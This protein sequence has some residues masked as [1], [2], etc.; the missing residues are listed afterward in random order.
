MGVARLGSNKLVFLKAVKPPSEGDFSSNAAGV[1]GT[2]GL[3]IAAGFKGI[4]V[5]G[6]GASGV[7]GKL[8]MNTGSADATMGTAEPPV[9]EAVGASMLT[10][11]RLNGIATEATTVTLRN[12]WSVAAVGTPGGEATWSDGE[13]AWSNGEAAWS[14]ATGL[15]TADESSFFNAKSA[16]SH[17]LE[18]SGVED[19]VSRRE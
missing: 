15:R 16:R 7:Y 8:G 13:A 12:A 5:I 2:A 6:R 11:V 14:R 19:S 3:A 4:C 18:R 17:V 10:G 1:V 9:L